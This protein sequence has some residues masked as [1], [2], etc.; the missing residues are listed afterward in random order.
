MYSSFNQYVPETPKVEKLYEEEPSEFTPLSREP[1][2]NY[3]PLTLKPNYQSTC[4][5][6][7]FVEGYGKNQ[8][9]EDRRKYGFGSSHPSFQISDVVRQRNQGTHRDQGTQRDPKILVN[10]KSSVPGNHY[11]LP[12]EFQNYPYNVN[13]HQ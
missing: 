3:E 8:K 12:V 1:P 10:E 7:T 9:T 6:G 13:E 5:L 2:K 11:R 4:N